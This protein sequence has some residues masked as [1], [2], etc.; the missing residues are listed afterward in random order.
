MVDFARDA[1]QIADRFK[2]QLAQF[3]QKPSRFG[4]EQLEK[5]YRDFVGAAGRAQQDL[6]TAVQAMLQTV[7]VANRTAIQAE[8]ALGVRR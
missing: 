7:S 8:G 5:T 6:Q 2:Q 1:S 3:R 4:V